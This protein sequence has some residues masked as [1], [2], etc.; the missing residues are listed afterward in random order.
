MIKT[1]ILENNLIRHYSDDNFKIK[2]IET[3]IIYD[4][5]IDVIPCRY[6]YEETDIPRDDYDNDSTEP[7]DN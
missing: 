2:Q 5:A 1:E 6:T 4:E 3:G 7:I